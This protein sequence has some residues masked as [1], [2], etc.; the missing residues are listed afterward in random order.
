MR[1]A[2]AAGSENGLGK[3]PVMPDIERLILLV[4][5]DCNGIG[6]AAAHRCAERWSRAEHTVVKLMPRRPG[7][8]FN[9][10]AKEQAA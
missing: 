10:I 8:D 2:W 7:A 1:P 4:D 9:D 3:L 5:H 6:Q